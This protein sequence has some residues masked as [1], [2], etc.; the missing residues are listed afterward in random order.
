M[1]CLNLHPKE[2][3][4]LYSVAAVMVCLWGNTDL[5]ITPRQS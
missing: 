4:R 5:T 3:L 1:P 2:I